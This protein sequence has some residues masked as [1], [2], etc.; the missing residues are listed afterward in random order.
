VPKRPDITQLVAVSWWSL[1]WA[2]ER[3]S[4]ILSITRAISGSFSPIERPGTVVGIVLYLPRMSS[5]ASGLGSKV[6]WWEM[7]PPR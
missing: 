4:A 5:G 6:S 1:L 2:P 3:M 7:P